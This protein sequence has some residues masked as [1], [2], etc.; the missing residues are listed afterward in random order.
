MTY[1]VAGV[2]RVGM[3]MPQAPSKIPLRRRGAL[4][5]SAESEG[6]KNFAQNIAEKL[7]V[8]LGPIAMSLGGDVGDEADGQANQIGGNVK[9]RRSPF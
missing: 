6:K 8:S 4:R 3:S 5:C 9:V 1:L 7:D 2:L